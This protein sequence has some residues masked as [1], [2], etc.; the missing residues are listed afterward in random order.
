MD[1]DR[2]VDLDG[3]LAALREMA[4]RRGLD[5]LVISAPASLSWLTGARWN[6]PNTLDSS[7]FDIVVS[8]AATAPSLRVVTN[9]IEAPRLA[10]TELPNLAA[11][12]TI[13]PWWTAR[14]AMIPQGAAVGSDSAMPGC[15]DVSPDV[16]TLRRSLTA[17]E[18]GLL[19]VVC[20]EAAAAVG[21][22]A[23]AVT[24]AM[25]EYQAAAL[26]SQALLARSLEPVC[27][28]VAGDDRM[29]R[30]RHPL[31]TA[32][33][34][35][36][37]ASLVC[38]AR[39]HGLIASV[40][41]IVCF[42]SASAPNHERYRALLE[43]E[44]AFLDASRAGARLGD[45]VTA[46]TSAY[47]MTG[48]DPDEWQHHHQGGLSGWQPREFSA[49]T[50]SDVIVPDNSVLA[51]NPSAACGKVEDTCLAGADGIEPLCI[52]PDWPTVDVGGR[53]R[54]DLLLL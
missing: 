35:G 8:D 49:F 43:V 38:C 14:A 29:H 12:W 15:T 30:D 11:E 21:A 1:E 9:T 48:F 25:T 51:W 34:L 5:M 24:P 45:V 19:R 4:A 46:G 28:F 36:E 33:R 2:W 23:H 39:R 42:R 17:R 22:T 32:Q 52:D 47:G 54:P 16:A 20:A 53:A 37:R 10:A 40:T 50:D 7:C 44:K 41:R 6:V 27:L 18:R 31:P 3:K 26:L 13:V